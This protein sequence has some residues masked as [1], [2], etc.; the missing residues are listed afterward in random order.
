LS[1]D[2]NLRTQVFEENVRFFLGLENPVN[3][4]IS[5]TLRSGPSAS[6]F[7]VLNNG[8]TI[9]SPDVRLQGN[10]LHLTNFQIVNGCQTSNV[11]FGNRDQL[12]DVMVNIKVVETH[13]EDVFSELVRATNSQ[14]KIEGA[15]FLSLRPINKR[16]EQYF[17]TYESE[18]KLY[19]ERRDRQYVGQDIPAIRI[20]SLH[21]AMKCVTAMYCNRPDLAS[22][23]PKTMYA[24]LADTIFADENKEIVFYAACLTFY[25]LNLL[26]S[27]SVIP[28]NMKRFKWHMLPLVRATICGKANHQLNSRQVEAGAG[29]IVDTMAQHGTAATD[30]FLKVTKICQDLGPVTSDQL[31]RQAIFNEMLA[32]IP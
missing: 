2:G 17:N 20:F 12:H 23:Y 24:E 4:S 1:T 26:V 18:G 22:R 30:V 15:Q 25:R 27:N 29:T 7:P 28:Q 8:I 9:V 14:S 19:F 11:L 5:A 6:R 32:K 13:N 10:T 31:K 21:N 3:Q 16:V